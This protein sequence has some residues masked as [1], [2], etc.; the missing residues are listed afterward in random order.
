MQAR[1]AGAGPAQASGARWPRLILLIAV[2]IEFL[3]ALSNLPILVGNL[4]EVPGLNLGG[5]VIIAKIVLSPF[6]ALAALFFAIRG[7]MCYA[8]VAFAAGI[9]LTAVSWVPTVIDS[10]F[11]LSGGDGAVNIYEVVVVPLLAIA[12]IVLAYRGRLTLAIL[13]AVVPTFVGVAA[14]IAFGI[15]IAIYGF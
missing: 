8:I 4:A 6:I 2:A 14:T 12:A 7:R 15:G 5:L 13:L 9:L 3:T 1:S 11:T 10:G